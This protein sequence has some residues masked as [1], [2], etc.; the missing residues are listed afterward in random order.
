[1]TRQDEIRLHAVAYCEES[2]SYSRSDAFIAG[3][4]WA[5]KN[6]CVDKNTTNYKRGLIDGYRKYIDVELRTISA[7]IK[8][9]E[10]DQKLIDIIK[11]T[12][13]LTKIANDIINK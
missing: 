7:R 12:Q 11:A 3:A 4:E 6:P 13:K 9:I 10:N 2:D 5:D 8:I 1:M